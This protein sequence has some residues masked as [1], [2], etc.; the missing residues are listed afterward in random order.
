M[1][2][3]TDAIRHLVAESYR[4]I[5]GPA[6]PRDWSRQA[7][8]FIGA[9]TLRVIHHHGTG[10]RVE[11]MSLRD[12]EMSRGPFFERQAFFERE[13]HSDILVSGDI[14]HAMSAYESRWSLDEPP[15]ETGVNSIQLVRFDGE[16]RIASI[17]WVAGSASKLIR[18]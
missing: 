4:V 15:F 9:A 8:L 6:G 11:T 16:W 3:D 5:S 10:S 1:T 12:Y 18:S 17:M 14:A 13:V 2:S 7:E